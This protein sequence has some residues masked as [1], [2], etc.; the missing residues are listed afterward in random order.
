MNK[1]TVLRCF[2]LC[3]IVSQSFFAQ[4]SKSKK[5]KY[6]FVVAQGGSGD[7]KNGAGSI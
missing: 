1:L 6:N 3:L 2:I 7:Y 4:I 5:S